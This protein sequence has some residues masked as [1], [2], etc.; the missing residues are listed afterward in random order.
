MEPRIFGSL[1]TADAFDPDR[2]TQIGV[3]LADGVDGDFTFDIDWI[4]ACV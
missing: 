1:V 4:D 3:I 2:A